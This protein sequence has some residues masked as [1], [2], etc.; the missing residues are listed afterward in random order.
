VFPRLSTGTLQLSI[1]CSSVHFLPN[2]SLP[3]R[4]IAGPDVTW[5]RGASP[6]AVAKAQWQHK[7][8]VSSKNVDRLNN[9]R[10]GRLPVFVLLRREP[11]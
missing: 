7:M 5:L 3:V 4:E 11:R 6:A 10:I 9:A 8:V 1:R 2:R